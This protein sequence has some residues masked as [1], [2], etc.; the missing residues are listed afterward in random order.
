MVRIFITLARCPACAIVEKVVN[1]FNVG[2]PPHKQI[3]TIYYQSPPSEKVRH[4][5][6]QIYTRDEIINEGLG[7]PIII[8]DG[9]VIRR[10]RGRH[11]LDH[12]EELMAMLEELDRYSN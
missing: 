9:I 1:L 8:F 12:P 6:S 2:R 7:P 5:I 3:R 11:Y 4:Y 10:K